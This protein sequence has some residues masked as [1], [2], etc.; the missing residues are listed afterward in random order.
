MT[1]AGIMDGQLIVFTDPEGDSS[2]IMIVVM[3]SNPEWIVERVFNIFKTLIHDKFPNCIPYFIVDLHLM[4]VVDKFLFVGYTSET[5][6]QQCVEIAFTPD[7]P[8]HRRFKHEY[9]L[10]TNMAMV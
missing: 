10:G 8:E 5:L 6:C 7:H 4:K 2:I 1:C 3:A 9:V